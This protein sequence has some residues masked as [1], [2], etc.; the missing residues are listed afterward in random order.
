M[1]CTA[2]E[3]RPMN[4][5]AIRNGSA[6]VANAAASSEAAPSVITEQISARF[7]TRSPSG[8]MKRSPTP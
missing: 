7:S 4:S 5:A 6:W 8:T 2:T 1:I 3:P